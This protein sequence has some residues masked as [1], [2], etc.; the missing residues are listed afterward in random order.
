MEY[1]ICVIRVHGVPLIVLHKK[2]DRGTARK[3]IREI[4]SIQISSRFRL[5]RR[6]VVLRIIAKMNEFII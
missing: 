1:A 2:Q 5:I 3:P 6:V 4:I